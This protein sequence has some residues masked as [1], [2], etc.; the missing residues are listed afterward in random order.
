MRGKLLR[1]NANANL[2]AINKYF[3]FTVSTSFHRS[4]SFDGLA[5]TT[6][7]NKRS[8]TPPSDKIFGGPSD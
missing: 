2:D 6:T 5:I 3:S 4:A 7:P 1:I 8:S